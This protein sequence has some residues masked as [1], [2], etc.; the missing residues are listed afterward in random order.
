MDLVKGK[1]HAELSDVKK[2]KRGKVT[3]DFPNLYGIVYFP[4]YFFWLKGR[5]IY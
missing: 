2:G 5:Y 1:S 4:S 3:G